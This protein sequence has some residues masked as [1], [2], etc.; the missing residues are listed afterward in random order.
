[1]D[2]FMDIFIAAITYVLGEENEEIKIPQ[3]QNGW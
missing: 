3:V 2:V 1:M